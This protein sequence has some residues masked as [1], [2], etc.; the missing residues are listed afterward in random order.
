MPNA[1][2]DTAESPAG[3][4]AFAV[5]A[6]GAL[7]R[8]QFVAGHYRMRIEQELERTGY[9]VAREQRRTAQWR[10]QL[11]EYA[12]GA[13]QSFDLPLALLGTAWQRRV[14]LAL[15]D[16]PFGETRSYG[17]LA[18]QLGRPLAARAVGHANGANPLPLV[19]PCHRLVGANGA[20][21]GYGGGLDLKARLLAHEAQVCG[22]CAGDA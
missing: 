4:L 16:I 22:Q 1:Y 20:L 10:A 15:I 21:T 11:Q 17:A 2:L 19:V 6:A 5:D 18:A 7:L 3:P 9:Q 8:T 14:W 12:H 13:R